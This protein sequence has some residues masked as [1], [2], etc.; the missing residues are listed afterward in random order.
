MKI[1]VNTRLLIQN[2][3]E[4]IGL[5]TNETLK[6]ITKNHPEHEF[7]FIFDRP[8]AEEFI[9]GSNVKAEVAR[10]QARH[11]LLWYLFFEY[12]IPAVLQRH[13]NIDLFLS[14]DGWVS[15]R[16]PVKTLNVIHDLNFEEHPEFIPWHIRKYYH[17]FFPRFALKSDRLATVSEYTRRDL[18]KFYGCDYDKIDVLYN[19]AHEIYHPLKPSEVSR[20]REKVTAGCPYFA[21]LGLIH[22][23]KNLKNT[24]LAFDQFKKTT[25]NNFQMVVIGEKKW[26]PDDLQ[27][28]Y[29]SIEH[30]ND[31]IFL[32]RLNLQDLQHVLASAFAL[33]YVSFFEGFGIPI[34]EAMTC[35]VPVITSN[36]TS[37]PEVGGEAALYANPFS[38]ESIKER[39]LELYNNNDLR[40]QLICKGLSQSANF[41]WDKTAKLLWQSVEKCI[42]ES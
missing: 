37:M 2:K 31:V 41:S 21:F 30:K 10:P 18:A 23:R 4:G 38:V 15:L 32:G 28:V 5:F 40:K 34:L 35:G 11:P 16:S 13:K 8:P 25:V 22:P 14:T 12:G 36:N 26:W 17:H 29:D 6:R 1:A 24:L 20:I 42:A 19:G 3:L 27:K 33:L 9:F 7:I 39:M